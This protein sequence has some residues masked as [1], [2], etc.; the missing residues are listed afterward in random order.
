MDICLA[1]LCEKKLLLTR[2]FVLAS[3][4]LDTSIIDETIKDHVWDVENTATVSIPSTGG[5]TWKR[6]VSWTWK[7]P[8]SDDIPSSGYFA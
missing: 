6:G 2:L 5:G 3:A 1:I 7:S 8:Q 4:L